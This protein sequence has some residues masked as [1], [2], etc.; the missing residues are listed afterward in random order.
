MSKIVRPQ[1]IEFK[2][3]EQPNSGIITIHPC[4]PGFGTTL[5]NSLRRVLLS[6]LEGAAVVGA[7]I[8]GVDHEFSTLPHIKEDV[9]EIILNLKQLRL[10]MFTEDENEVVRLELEAHGKKEVTAADITKNSNVEIVNPDLHIATITDMAGNLSMEIFVKRGRGYET[11]DQR[12][13]G[14]KEIGFIEID[15]AYSPILSVGV[16]VENVRV[17]KM[18]NWDKLILSLI[19]DGTITPQQAFQ[20]SVEILIDQLGALLNKEEKKEEKSEESK[21]EKKSQEE[22]LDKK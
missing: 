3:G 4:Y 21:E 16:K 6:S 11:V 18:T 8:K 7:K 2:Q 9:L 10:K 15:S 14:K 12:G 17:G 13:T 5:G 20:E 1:N 19:T 22:I